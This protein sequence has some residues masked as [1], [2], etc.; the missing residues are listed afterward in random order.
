MP[1]EVENVEGNSFIIC[2]R[3][4]KGGSG[5]KCAYCH[6]ASTRLCD[7]PVGGVKETCDVP[8]CGF[9]TH[10]AG[11]NR[12]LCRTHR[13]DV[14]HRPRQDENAPRWMKAIYSGVCYYCR[15]T[16]KTGEKMLW[17]KKPRY[18]Y[19]ESCGKAHQENKDGQKFQRM[20]ER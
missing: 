15:K 16:V 9:C 20:V 8:M 6:R 5:Q 14:A 11:R 1:C 13:G 12:D 18:L 7:Y 19:C 3:G 17:F 2:H 10:K 4:A